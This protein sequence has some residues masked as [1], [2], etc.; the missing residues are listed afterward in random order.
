MLR[1]G[2]DVDF[3]SFRAGAQSITE[4][5]EK[6]DIT[7]N[8]LAVPVHDLLIGRCQE[9]DKLPVIDPAGGLAD[10]KQ[11]RVRAVTEKSFPDDP[12]RMLRVFRF[13]AVLDFTVE[14]DTLEQVRQQRK[15]IDLVAKERVAYELDLIMASPRAHRAFARCVSAVCFG[16]SCRSCRQGRAWGSLP[17]IIWMC[18]SIA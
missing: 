3:S 8:A 15:S 2:L 7:V 18:L 6:R 12:L 16:K 13:A 17:V 11:Q 10:L 4:D 1:Q 5:L 9:Q 14:S